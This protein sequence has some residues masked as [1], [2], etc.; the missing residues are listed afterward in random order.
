MAQRTQVFKSEDGQVKGEI[1]RLCLP[2]EG[3]DLTDDE[4]I[5]H[6]SLWVARCFGTTAAEATERAATLPNHVRER[7]RMMLP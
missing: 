3:A 7:L 6:V 4:Y 5:G 2:K 1:T